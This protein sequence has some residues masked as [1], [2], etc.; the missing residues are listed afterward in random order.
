[1]HAVDVPLRRGQQS[2][3][4]A[5]GGLA[6]VFGQRP[7]GFALDTGQQPFDAGTG[8]QAHF[9]PSEPACDVGERVIQLPLASDVSQLGQPV[10]G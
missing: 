3:H 1:M 7:T 6:G 9:P 5:W 10:L 4:P 8:A 2:L